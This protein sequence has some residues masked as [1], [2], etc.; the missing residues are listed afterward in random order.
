MFVV[1]HCLT[2]SSQ[3]QKRKIFQ[4]KHQARK[5]DTFDKMMQNDAAAPMAATTKAPPCTFSLVQTPPTTPT[6]ATMSAHQI[7]SEIQSIYRTLSSLESL[8]PSV[9]VNTL[10]TRLV[11]LCVVPYSETLSSYFFAISGV[12]DL[13]V[14]LRPICSQAEGELERYWANRIVEIASGTTSSS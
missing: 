14:K 1:L 11:N 13:C 12:E 7:L 8:A 2:N 5:T 9:P 4:L 6:T 10:L 3:S